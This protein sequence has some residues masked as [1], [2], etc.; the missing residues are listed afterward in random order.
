MKATKKAACECFH[1]CSLQNLWD[2]RYRNTRQLQL[3]YD[4]N[5]ASK[6]SWESNHPNSFWKWSWT[7]QQAIGSGLLH[8]NDDDDDICSASSWQCRCKMKHDSATHLQSNYHCNTTDDAAD[9]SACLPNIARSW[10][11]RWKLMTGFTHSLASGYSQVR[12]MTT[13]KY[14]F[15]SWLCDRLSWIKRRRSETERK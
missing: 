9:L 14:C 12:V 13:S 5:D 1:H 2:C 8:H 15:L 7:D 4:T 6:M 10:R 11:A 3:T